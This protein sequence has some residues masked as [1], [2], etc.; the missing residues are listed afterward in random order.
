[1]VPSVSTHHA[2]S[3]AARTGSAVRAAAFWTAVALP[4]VAVVLLALG[5]PLTWIGLLLLGNAAAFVVGH[6]YRT[7]PNHEG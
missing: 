7:R 5:V 4:F 3:A 2:R 6:D 1:M